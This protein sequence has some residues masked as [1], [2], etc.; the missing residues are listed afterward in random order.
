[1]RIIAGS[2]GGR[3]VK[4]PQSKCIRPTTEK[5]KESLFNW[6]SCFID[7]ED[8]DACDIYAGSGSLGLELLSRGARS[9]DFV[10]KNFQIY[11]IL[12]ENIENLRQTDAAKI[13]KM[14]GLRFSKM[15][16]HPI[17]DLILADPPFFHYDIHQV[18]KNLLGRG[19]LRPGGFL[20]IER[21]IQT[22]EKDNAAFGITPVKRLG[23]SIIY[24]FES[25]KVPEEV[26]ETSDVPGDL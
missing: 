18:V 9:L 6:M 5:F 23:D 26:N 16:D 25:Q 4:I 8:I 21:S 2:L 20:I 11:K 3:R 24:K 12:Q 19:Y 13:F 7:F 15:K 22:E 17:Y 1:M 14:D 10:E